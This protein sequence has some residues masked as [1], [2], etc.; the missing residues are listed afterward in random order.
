MQVEKGAINIQ[1]A[2]YWEVIFGLI[3]ISFSV[4]PM[5][6]IRCLEGRGK[7]T[8]RKKDGMN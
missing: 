6:Q 7:R 2:G 8:M 5:S 4:P 3:A 1:F